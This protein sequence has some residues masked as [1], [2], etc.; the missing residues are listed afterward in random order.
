MQKTS[1]LFAE[2][3][4]ATI[5]PSANKALVNSRV[6][7][8][9]LY[10]F[11]VVLGL[12]SVPK[13][14]VSHL[15]GP[16]STV[17]LFS[18]QGS[19]D[20]SSLGFSSLIARKSSLCHDIKAAQGQPETLPGPHKTRRVTWYNIVPAYTLHARYNFSSTRDTNRYLG[21]S[22]LPSVFIYRTG[23]QLSAYFAS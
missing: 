12:C 7:Y 17:R 21:I 13:G 9:T 15:G 23:S 11:F 2:I 22:R 3:P 5:N 18:T 14:L 1:I 4:R 10:W 20:A 19:R 16:H 6:D 8:R